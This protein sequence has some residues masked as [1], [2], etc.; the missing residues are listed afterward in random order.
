M[1]NVKWGLII[2]ILIFIGISFKLFFGDILEF[3]SFLTLNIPNKDTLR[4]FYSSLFQG[5]AAIFSLS[6]MFFVFYAE[7]MSTILTKTISSLRTIIEEYKLV[8]NET[9][10]NYLAT[11]GVF[12]FINEIYFKKNRNLP[13][14]CSYHNSII[15][16]YNII[17]FING[18]QIVAKRKLKRLILFSLLILCVSLVCLFCI[19]DFENVNLLIYRIGLVLIVISII[20]FI[21]LGKFL[22][23]CFNA[24]F[25]KKDIL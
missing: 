12:A 20:Y 9:E 10:N 4:Y 3:L 22:F 24:F 17:N 23:Y 1:K 25:A 16:N 18:H 14:N 7:R 19:G 15:A 5:Y 11:M 2:L 8:T 6:G 13:S 21:Y